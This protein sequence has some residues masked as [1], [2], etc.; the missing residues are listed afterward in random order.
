MSHGLSVFISF[1]L[2]WIIRI[3]LFWES[4]L[5][6]FPF[7]GKITAKWGVCA[8]V[9]GEDVCQCQCVHVHRT[10]KRQFL[11]SW[12]LFDSDADVVA[13]LGSFSVRVHTTLKTARRGETETW[14]H[15]LSGNVCVYGAQAGE[16]RPYR[17]SERKEGGRKRESVWL[18]KTGSSGLDRRTR[19]VW[20]WGCS[21]PL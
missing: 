20:P 7:L 11:Q 4:G 14:L 1:C 5:K 17:L 21:R 15:F 3:I 13:V 2:V 12:L 6:L 10:F 19:R 18:V 8:P 9:H 16:E